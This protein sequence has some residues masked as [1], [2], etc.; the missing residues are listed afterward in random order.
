M[1]AIARELVLQE[2][3]SH[4]PAQPTIETVALL[5]TELQEV[6]NALAL[7]GLQR[8]CRCR[9]FL[10]SSEAGALFDYTEVVCYSCV[11]EVRVWANQCAR[12]R[13]ARVKTSILVTQ[14]SPGTGQ[15][16]SG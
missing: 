9:R 10:R 4:N 13:E 7:L 11:V 16:R 6:I 8:C 2:G 15:A 14:I 12:S 1:N 3:K 5:R